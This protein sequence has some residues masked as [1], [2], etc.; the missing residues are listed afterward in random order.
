MPMHAMTL[1]AKWV[2]NDSLVSYTVTVNNGTPASDVTV[3]LKQGMTTQYKADT[4]GTQVTFTGV[5]PG[6]YT[7]EVEKD[8]R[9]STQVVTI[10]ENGSINVTVP[11]DVSAE[12]IVMWN[13]P[14]VLAGGLNDEAQEIKKQDTT[15]T[16]VK[17]LLQV[18]G[19][20]EQDVAEADRTAIQ[21]ATAG[22][23]RLYLDAQVWFNLD[24]GEYKTRS[25]TKTV[26]ELIVPFD[27][28]GK[29]NLGVYRYHGNKAESF[30][31]TQ[32]NGSH[33]DG[34]FYLDGNYI[35]IFASKFSTYAIAYTTSSGGGTSS[36]GSSSGSSYGV[37]V[38]AKTE[39]GSVTVSPKSASKGST[40][41][42][43]VTPDQGYALKDLTV[44]DKDGKQ[45][46]LTEKDGKYTF[47]MPD[48]KVSVQASFAKEA[49]AQSFTDVPATA[50]YYD[51]VQ[52][53]AEQGITGGVGD[54]RFAP[55]QGCTRG[56]IVTF[57]WRAAGSPEP[58]A[59]STYSDVPADAYYAKAVAWAVENGITV[60]TS[61]TTFSP[62]MTCT[63]A[64][65]VTFL[66]RAAK[67]EPT[68]A[69]TAFTDVDANAY[70]ASA[71]N[72]A[73]ENGITNGVSSTLFGP[74][75][76]CTRAQIVTF[77]YRAYNK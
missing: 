72:W 30:Q 58:K 39:G 31:Q 15:A 71:V 28:S 50:Y 63:R 3:K 13:T 64:H 61:E 53:A 57:L 60:G 66:Y 7:L 27:M 56:Q 14:A 33:K 42:I 12:L 73:V 18:E 9:Y 52:W 54:G 24:N 10:T 29:Y 25:E 49:P 47:T 46:K 48:G 68:A 34:Q 67:A 51:A 5:V 62:D 70:Y 36:G 6:T 76:T 21:A 26:L 20:D 19:K 55:E 17:M 65:G 45:V 35:H 44:T 59:L 16:S 37:D 23:Q 43:T 11:A 1:Y 4:T 8:G 38:P 77:L 32:K 22:K 2:R 41:T 40:V 75:G 74:N 69:S